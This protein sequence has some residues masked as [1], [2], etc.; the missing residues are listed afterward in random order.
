MPAFSENLSIAAALGCCIQSKGET[1]NSRFE[2]LALSSNHVCMQ[3]D[4]YTQ[5]CF[6][7]NIAISETGR[8]AIYVLDDGA[9]S[10]WLQDPALIGAQDQGRSHP[11]GDHLRRQSNQPPRA[12]AAAAADRRELRARAARAGAGS[13]PRTRAART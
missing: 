11:R 3:F 5:N 2:N 8:R 1:V 10:L 4:G 9:V 13:A 12:G 7:H 6:I